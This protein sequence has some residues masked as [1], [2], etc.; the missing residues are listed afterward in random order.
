MCNVLN[1]INKNLFLLYLKNYFM[2][3]KNSFKTI[4]KYL[5]RLPR[6]CTTSVLNSYTML[7]SVFSS[8][9][10][11]IRICVTTALL[12]LMI[13]VLIQ[14]LCAGLRSGAANCTLLL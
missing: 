8:S 1:A 5:Q 10:K 13:A 12:I 7:M 9:V 14:N 11:P 3:Q 6:L 2:I 4:F